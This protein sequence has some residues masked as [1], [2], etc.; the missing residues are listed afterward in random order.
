MATIGTR[1]CR[2]IDGYAI[3]ERDPGMSIAGEKVFAFVSCKYDSYELACEDVEEAIKD[4]RRLVVLWNSFY[5]D[6]DRAMMTCYEGCDDGS[7]KGVGYEVYLDP[8][9]HI[10]IG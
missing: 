9:T 7:V 3:T 8:D 4:A 5:G 6:V 2:A 10:S 1:P